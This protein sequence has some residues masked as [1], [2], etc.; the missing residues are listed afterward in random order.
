MQ[1]ERTRGR[2][3]TDCQFVPRLRNPRFFDGRDRPTLAAAPSARYTTNK[4]TRNARPTREDRMTLPTP[5]DLQNS[6]ETQPAPP[7]T[8]RVPPYHVI[9]LND[10]HHSMPFVIEVLC[11]VLG[12]AVE[13]AFQFMM[14]AHTSGRAVI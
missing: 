8:R 5:T 4:R 14:E 12:I 7:Q 11:K 10:D 3:R 1:T 6:T 2:W 9:L 13:R